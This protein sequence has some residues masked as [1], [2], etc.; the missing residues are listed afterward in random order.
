MSESGDTEQ[1]SVQQQEALKKLLSNLAKHEAGASQELEVTRKQLQKTEKE[2]LLIE[3]G[4]RSRHTYAIEDAKDAGK[5][6]GAEGDPSDKNI[7][8]LMNK[9]K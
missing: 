7:A 2:Q 3:G 4:K 8:P 6:W 9:D 1:L 5:D